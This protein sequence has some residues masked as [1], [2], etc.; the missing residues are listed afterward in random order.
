MTVNDAIRTNTT[1]VS[2][3]VTSGSGWSFSAPSV[4]NTGNVV[5][6]KASVANGQSAVFQI[7]VKVNANTA[8]GTI[9]TNNATAAATTTDPNSSNNTGTT[10]TT[11]QV[12]TQR[13]VVEADGRPDDLTVLHILKRVQ[14]LIDNF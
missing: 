5:F 12:A 7:V 1:F 14:M 8:N 4:G 10:M 6:S 11:V 9:I 2:A 13:W 3:A